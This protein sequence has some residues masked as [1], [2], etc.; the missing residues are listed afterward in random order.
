[1]NKE[2]KIELM[3]LAKNTN[4]VIHKI[5]TSLATL[6]ADPKVKEYLK[7]KQALVSNYLAFY[8][9]ASKIS[10]QNPDC[11]HE[12]LVEVSRGKYQ[13]GKWHANSYLST[14]VCY[15]CLECNQEFYYSFNGIYIGSNKKNTS[16]VLRTSKEVFKSQND[17]IPLD[18]NTL[19]RKYLTYLAEGYEIDDILIKLRMEGYQG[20]DISNKFSR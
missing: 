17:G 1:M 6:E 15:K 2:Q 12:I 20:Y 14:D 13:K 19:K 11:A 5:N 10:R 3:A 8:E 4:E 18:F 7:L 16:N 9:Q